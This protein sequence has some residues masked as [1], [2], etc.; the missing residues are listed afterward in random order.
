[1]KF[2]KTNIFLLLTCLLMSF[3]LIKDGGNQNGGP[4]YS[5]G[6]TD[7]V[8]TVYNITQEF[9]FGQPAV[10]FKRYIAFVMQTRGD[11][12][13]KIF[14]GNL[15][16]SNE[17]LIFASNNIYTD[18]G[19]VSNG[20]GNKK[21]NCDG[22][23]GQQGFNYHFKR[24]QA[25]VELKN[26]DKINDTILIQNGLDINFTKIKN[27]DSILVTVTAFNGQTLNR[28]GTGLMQSAHFTSVELNNFISGGIISI[29]A[30]NVLPETINNKNY[31]FGSVHQYLKLVYFKNNQL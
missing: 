17:N 15:S 12:T 7:G 9:N 11:T 23:T 24:G 4:T 5:M 20:N 2:F 28:R 6:N 22:I 14:F 18:N 29:S 21:W 8:F 30:Y 31:L 1:M 16:F 10:N 27:A 13:S 3:S 26:N 25:E 19:S